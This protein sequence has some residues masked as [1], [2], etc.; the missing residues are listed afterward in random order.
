M[1][2]KKGT[3]K[4][5]G[6][7][8]KTTDQPQDIRED[9]FTSTSPD[10][11]ARAILEN[12]YHVQAGIRQFATRNDWYMALAYTVR[13]RMLNRWVKSINLLTKNTKEVR[14]VSYLSA[15]FLVGPHLGNNLISLG[16]Y[17]QVRLAVTQLGLIWMIPR[18][19]GGTRIGKWRP[20]KAGCVFYGFPLDASDPRHRIWNSL[21]V[22][23][24]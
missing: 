7:R 21:R 8:K 16:I 15:E 24:F 13:D 19:G 18:A 3:T 12:L 2:E 10:V 5:P 6:G 11:I 9:I 23:N 22:W 4:K 20:G 1:L 17:D 14:F